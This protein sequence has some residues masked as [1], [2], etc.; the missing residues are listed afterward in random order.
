MSEVVPDLPSGAI[1]AGHNLAK[2]VIIILITQL[3]TRKF[4]EVK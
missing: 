2:I 1:L 3:K 4:G